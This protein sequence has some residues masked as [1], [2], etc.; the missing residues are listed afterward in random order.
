MRTILDDSKTWFLHCLSYDKELKLILIEGI[1]G[2]TPEDI[3]IRDT[4]ICDTY[5]INTSPSS[6]MVQI[7]FPHFIAWQV[8]DES[9][10]SFDEYE[11]RDDKSFLQILERSKYFDYV[12]ASHGW[13]ADAIGSG[14]HYRIWTENEVI[15][16]VSCEEPIIEPIANIS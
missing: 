7:R 9:F 1:V 15:D 10:T 2:T 4:I 14:R 12:N 3:K 13:Y 16:V 5:P 8:V 11:K 6:K